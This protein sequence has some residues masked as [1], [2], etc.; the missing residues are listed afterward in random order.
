MKAWLPRIALFFG[1]TPAGHAQVKDAGVT[2]NL[3]SIFSGVNSIFSS[4][5]IVLGVG[6]I[7]AAIIQYQQYRMNPLLVPISKP[8]LWVIF[9]LLLILIPMLKHYTIGGLLVT[10]AA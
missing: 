6:F 7:F 2:T 1:V 8:L 5:C 10:T 4:I 3:L 9:G